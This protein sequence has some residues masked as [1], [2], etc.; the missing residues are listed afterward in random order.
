[1]AIHTSTQL[2]RTGTIAMD[3]PTTTVPL[4]TNHHSPITE[5]NSEQTKKENER[6]PER[7]A[8]VKTLVTLL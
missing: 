6:R 4:P 7:A 5:P 8:A 1:M 3:Y 2:A